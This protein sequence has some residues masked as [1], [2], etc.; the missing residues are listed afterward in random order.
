MYFW[1]IILVTILVTIII[2][3]LLVVHNNP[4]RMQPEHTAKH[5]ALQLGSLITLYTSLAALIMLSF[6][7]ITIMYP[8]P[9]NGYYEYDGAASAIRFGIALLIVFFPVYVAL[10]RIVNTMRRKEQ[11]EYLTITKWLIYL[12]LIVGGAILLGDLV[13][14]VNGFLNGE[15]TVRFLLKA[16][17]LLVVVGSAFLYYFYD[18]RQYWQTHEKLSIRAGIVAG[19]VVV[20]MLVVGFTSI[21]A[22]TEVRERRLDS[23][24][25][26]DLSMIQSRVEEYYMVNQKLPES[27]SIAFA[28]LSIP[29]ASEGRAA[30]Q[31]EKNT[32]T[33]FKLCAEFFAA[34]AKSEQAMYAQPVYYD[35]AIIKN[36]YNWEHGAG[37]WCFERILN[38]Q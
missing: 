14:V 22:P 4:L 27:V 3:N 15:L 34:T 23:Q 12:S 30:Y 17:T 38:T 19:V 26:N 21:E 28:S 35:K 32:E 11:G 18:A 7:V 33:T 29:T 25:I 36:P 16:L 2:I 6:G 37:N 5:F 10:T 13:A 20:V 9:A 8:D 31:Y 24:Q 1:L